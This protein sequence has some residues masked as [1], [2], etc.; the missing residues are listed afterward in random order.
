MYIRVHAVPGA[1]KETVTKE[2]DTVFYIAVKE[3][4]EQNLANKRVREILAQEFDVTTAQ[5]RM[6][7]GH[8]SRSKMYSIEKE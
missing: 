6:L 2:S 7:T 3:P 1:R 4:A 5:V 8:H